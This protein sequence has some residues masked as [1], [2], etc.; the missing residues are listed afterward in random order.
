M[1]IKSEIS[2]ES[3]GYFSP[4]GSN[5]GN[6]ADGSELNGLI[7]HL[8]D[9]S[10]NAKFYRKVTKNMPDRSG[11]LADRSNS[12][13]INLTPCR[14]IQNDPNDLIYIKKKKEKREEDF[15]KNNPI[16]GKVSYRSFPS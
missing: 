12:L 6:L 3:Y 13:W 5:M 16:L 1:A 7:E 8:T 14:S 4:N 2:R 9:R 11:I 15:G 10:N